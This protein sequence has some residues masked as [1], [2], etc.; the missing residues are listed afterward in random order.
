MK[1]LLFSIILITNT[2]MAQNMNS[3]WLSEKQK[4]IIAIS[5]VTAKGEKIS[6][7]PAELKELRNAIAGIELAGVRAPESMLNEL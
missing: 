3:N 6:F 1:I 2:V 7:T 5:A 4:I